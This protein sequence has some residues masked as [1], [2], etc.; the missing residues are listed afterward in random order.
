MIPTHRL[1]KNLGPLNY[2]GL[3]EKAG[4]Y[5]DI[6]RF[7]PENGGELRWKNA[8]QNG[9]ELKN[10]SIGFYAKGA[11]CIYVL[12]AKE[13]AVSSWLA[14][15]GTPP[16][17]RTLDVVVL[18]QIV[19]RELMGLSDEFLADEGN[20]S[21]IHDFTEAL[22]AVK[23]SGFEA[24]FFINHT[25]IEQV[26]E[27]ASAGLVMPHKSTYFYPKVTS[28]LVINPILPNEEII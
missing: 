14:Q 21:F 2:E 3:I 17:L 18:D 8:I 15:K 11:P 4:E 19:L 25:R 5:F 13:S 1:L 24:G 27:V 9:G 20:I 16:Q 12:T 28:G 7:T 22:K 26:S 10:T 23:S 6:E